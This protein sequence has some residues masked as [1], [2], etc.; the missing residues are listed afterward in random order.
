MEML[1]KRNWLI[2]ALSRRIHK[3]QFVDSSIAFAMES[4]GRVEPLKVIAHNKRSDSALS[5]DTMEHFRAMNYL[6]SGPA[7]SCG[8]D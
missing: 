8:L 6:D 3:M 1:M 5:K 4:T 2:G 7:L